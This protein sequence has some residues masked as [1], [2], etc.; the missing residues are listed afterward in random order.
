[1]AQTDTNYEELNTALQR[2]EEGYSHYL[3][4]KDKEAEDSV[5]LFMEGCIQRFEHCFDTAW[6]HLKKYLTEGMGLPET[7]N[8]PKPIFKLALSGGAI[9]DAELW[10]DFN[11]KRIMS[12]HGYSGEKAEEVFQIIPAFIKE[13]RALYETMTSEQ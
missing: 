3:F 11:N 13:A 8:S 5:Q 10:I 12:S 9:D 4:N 1:M 2:L 6:K 7:P